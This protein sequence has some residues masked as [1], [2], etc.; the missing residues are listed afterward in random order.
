MARSNPR[1]VLWEKRGKSGL[2]FPVDRV[3]EDALLDTR[4][5]AAFLAVSPAAL[6]EWRKL[7]RRVGPD[8]IR[9]QRCVRYSLEDLRRYVRRQMVRIAKSARK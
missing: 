2:D 4:G 9:V 8:F 1:T 3:R 5:A 7:R 6:V